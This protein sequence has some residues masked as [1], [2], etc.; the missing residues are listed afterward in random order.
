MGL[1]VD[2][3]PTESPSL[4]L[5]SS[6]VGGPM[7]EGRRTHVTSESASPVI[8]TENLGVDWHRIDVV[9]SFRIQVPLQSMSLVGLVQGRGLFL[10]SILYTGGWAP[11]DV[12]S[13]ERPPGSRVLCGQ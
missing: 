1:D 11:V 8:T 13:R 3:G 5:G 4:V 2:F 7:K 10:C 9:G 12:N 6:E